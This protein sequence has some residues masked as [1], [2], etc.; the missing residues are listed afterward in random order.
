M[1]VE[2]ESRGN[3]SLV[4]SFSFNGGFDF[5]FQ[6]SDLGVSFTSDV[7]WILSLFT[8]WSSKV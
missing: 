8:D 5:V 7:T 3:E 6:F 1:E 4:F 2:A